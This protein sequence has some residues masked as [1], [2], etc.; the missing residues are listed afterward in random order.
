M[1]TSNS[2]TSNAI[3]RS[4][5]R[6]FPEGCPLP[7]SNLI[8]FDQWLESIDKTPATGWRWRKRGWISTINIAGRV[9]IDRAEIKRF[10][11]RAANGEFSKVHATPARK[12]ADQ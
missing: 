2:I 10:E 1:T 8:P 4:W 11:E 6:A 12:V 3:A 7:A 9:Y 5:R